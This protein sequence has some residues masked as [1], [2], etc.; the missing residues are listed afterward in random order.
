M[1]WF[2]LGAL[3][4]KLL[5]KHLFLFMAN[6]TRTLLRTMNVIILLSPEI[7]SLPVDTI[8]KGRTASSV[9][10]GTIDHA[11]KEGRVSYCCRQ[12][13]DDITVYHHWSACFNVR[14]L[15]TDR[16]PVGWDD[17]KETKTH[18]RWQI[19]QGVSS[20]KSK[21]VLIVFDLNHRENCVMH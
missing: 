19:T 13:A 21:C 15:S 3:H 11:M 6:N 1:F 20:W 8:F 17:K 9:Y 5:M 14:F 4:V 18:H 12:K 7:Q 16:L 2:S 10:L